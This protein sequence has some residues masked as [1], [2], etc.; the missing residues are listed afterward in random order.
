MKE[1]QDRMHGDGVYKWFAL[2]LLFV[3]FFL[4]QGT[5]QIFGAMLPQIQGFFGVNRTE[6]GVVGTVFQL[7]YGLSLPFAGLAADLFGRKRMVVIGVAMFC[8]GIF[9][10][11]FAAG[12]GNLALAY[13]LMNGSGQ[14]A[15]YPGMTSLVSQLHSDSRATAFSIIQC[16]LYGGILICS[17]LSGW[18]AGMS[19][20][21]WRIPF[22]AFGGIGL[23]W[24]VVLAL[25]LRNTQPQGGGAVARPSFREAFGAILPKRSVWLLTL[26]LGTMI[27]VDVGFKIWTPTFL[28]DSFSGLTSGAAALHAVLWHYLGAFCGITAAARVTDRFAASRR[29]L[30]MEINILGLA[31]AAPFIFLMAKAGSLPLCCVAMGLF[32]FFR[33]VYD[34]NILAALFDVVDPRYHATASSCMLACAATMGSAAP[35]V[36]GWIGD[37]ASLRS[38][39]ASLSLFYLVGAVAIAVAS[40]FFLENEYVGS[41]TSRA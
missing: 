10:G 34:S 26:A 27:Y 22:W 16:G 17:V 20:E 4:H 39:F 30:R 23:A 32:G 31:V 6:I 37:N 2:G 38:G 15:Y 41:G 9:L 3:A 18:V 19:E 35:T 29:G 24:A 5:R 13:G 40:V 7:A 36:L 21:A 12:V 11:G 28:R 25:L 8:G 14:A 1:Q 33:G